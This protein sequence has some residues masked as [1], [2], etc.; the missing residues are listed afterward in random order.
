MIGP[1]WNQEKMIIFARWI[2]IVAVFAGLFFFLEG[3]GFPN[4]ANLVKLGAG[5]ILGA[6]FLS[7]MFG[8]IKLSQYHYFCWVF[9]VT[10]ITLLILN[11]GGAVYAAPKGAMGVSVNMFLF[12]YPLLVLSNSSGKPWYSGMGS[13]LIVNGVIA[14]LFSRTATPQWS[15]FAILAVFNFALGAFF[16]FAEQWI[17]VGDVDEAKKKEKELEKAYEH[18]RKEVAQREKR[19]QELF[20]KTRKLTTVIQV[21]RMLGSSL[22]LGDLFE[23]MIEKA[24]EEMNSS[25]AFVMLLDNHGSLEVVHSIG[26]SEITKDLF[27]GKVMP[28]GGL[29]SDV[30]LQS[31]SYRLNSRDHKEVLGQFAGSIEKIRTIIL[32]PLKAPKDD[33]PLGVLG[34]ANML[35]GEEYGA[36]H[37]DFLGI[38]AIEAAMFIKQLKLREDLERSYFE[39]IITLAQAIEA[40]DPYTR[41]H[42]NRVADFAIRLAKALKLPASEVARVEK[43]A[44]LHDVGKIATPE[45]ILNKPGRLTDEEFCIM[46]DHVVESKKMLQEITT[47]LDEQIKNYVGYHHERWD[48]KGYPQGLK[49]EEIPLGAQIIAVADTFDAMTSDRPYRKGFANEEAL[50]MLVDSAGTQFNPR[51]LYAFF[52]LMDF[53]QKTGKIKPRLADT[54]EMPVQKN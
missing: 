15:M 54:V 4:S 50:K 51:V 34:V 30:I 46:K 44:I 8:R 32:V 26:M 35:V 40:K 22:H 10:L 33:T 52:E 1:E 48:G 39:L 11:T 5:A 13:A 42:V 7:A 6:A 37:E 43:A 14:W 18:L 21:S 24:R 12:L 2:L 53:D 17:V 20:D 41:G 29:M 25:L 27:R 28:G 45:H 16:M 36:D 3:Q 23:I 47:G 9:D 19:E 31:K 49:G 38:F